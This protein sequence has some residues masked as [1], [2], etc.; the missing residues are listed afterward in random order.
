MALVICAAVCPEFNVAQTVVRFVGM[1]PVTPA[2]L[3]S[4]AREGLM[5]PVQGVAAKATAERRIQQEIPANVRTL[6]A[7]TPLVPRHVVGSRIQE[8]CNRTEMT[9]T[10]ACWAETAF[11]PT[12][13][14]FDPSRRAKQISL[15]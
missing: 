8:F 6:I 12:N 5:M 7:P 11:R 15:L 13:A 14:H 4:V 2:V 9:S 3:Q 1:P 10:F